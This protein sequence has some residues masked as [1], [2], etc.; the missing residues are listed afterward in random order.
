[1]KY[2]TIFLFTI[3]YANAM[4][5]SLNSAKQSG[6]PYATIHLQ[7]DEPILCESQNR[8]FG[9]KLY[10]CMFEGDLKNKIQNKKTPYA[11]I[12][13]VSEKEKFY[14]YIKPKAFSQI[15]NADAKLYASETT[16]IKS[17]KNAK[18]WTILIYEKKPFSSNQNSDGINF[19]I[20]YPKFQYPSVGALDLNDKPIDYARTNDINLYLDIKKYYKRKKYDTVLETISQLTKKYPRSI[21]MS[22][23]LL[24]RL[25]SLDKM[26]DLDDELNSMKLDRTDVVTEAKK[27]LKTFPTDKNTPEV[28]SIIS[29]S[30]LDVGFKTEANYFLD[31]LVSEYPDDKYTQ[32]AVLNYA[33]YLHNGK[34]KKEAIKL[35]EDVLYSA[36]DLDVASEAAIRLAKNSLK[37]GKKQKAKDY[38]DKILNANK[39]FIFQDKDEAYE[40]AQSLAKEGLYKNAATIINNLMKNTK[41]ISPNYEMKLKDAGVWNEKAKNINIAYEFL[42]KYQKEFAYGDYKE[43]VQQSLD[44]LFFELKETNSTKL[45]NYYDELIKRYKNEIGTKALVAK[46]KLLLKQKKYNEVLSMEKELLGDKNSTKG[47]EVLDEAAFLAITNA[48]KNDQCISAVSISDTHEKA[49]Q[50]VEDR[51]KLY[52]CFMRTSRYE[53]AKKLAI[54]NARNKNLVVKLVWLIRLESVLFAQREYKQT[55]KIAKDVEA[56][57]DI[58]KNDKANEALYDRFFALE[59]LGDYANALQIADKIEKTMPNRFKNVEVYGKIVKMAKS[60]GNDMIVTLYAQ[61]ALNLQNKADS[62]ILSPL[63]EYDY[64]N[65][66]QKLNKNEQANKIALSVL[67]RDLNKAQRGRALYVVAESFAKLND[68]KNARDYFA[69]CVK[70]DESSS[71]GGICSENLAL[72]GEDLNKTIDKNS[73]KTAQ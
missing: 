53:K 2:I 40:L 65:A 66:L 47:V 72:F 44:R 14:I 55:I 64:I 48:L 20:T 22:D 11:D 8:A 38:L 10:L 60:Q 26:L 16:P 41:R 7:N 57:G 33:D 18:H 24:Y 68:E 21:F 28:L 17:D 36:K 58:L 34:N 27:W 45:A 73:T 43:I 6:L 71:W 70:F 67:K 35:Y 59:K 29:K 30:Y 32:R 1:M 56:L 54:M 39:D 37:K 19:P 42:K 31:M 46:A 15:I 50:K 63:L 4:T 69:K 12:D 5:L 51:V 62:Y 49:L 3:F 9:L 52:S 13:F 61:K 25:R 23:V